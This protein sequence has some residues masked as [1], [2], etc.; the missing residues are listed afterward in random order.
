MIGPA[1]EE[2]SDEM[3]GKVKIV[4]VNIDE[5]PQTPMQYGVR[6]IPTLLIFDKGEVKAEKIGAAPKSKL[7]EWVEQSL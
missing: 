3:A 1:L 7:S 6:G 4:K 2:I 5:N